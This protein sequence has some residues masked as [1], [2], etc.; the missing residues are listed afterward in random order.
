DCQPRAIGPARGRA[1]PASAYDVPARP[2]A[3][4]HPARSTSALQRQPST[5]WDAAPSLTRE[6][7]RRNGEPPTR[8]GTARPRAHNT[9]ACDGEPAA[10]ERAGA[11]TKSAPKAFN[12]ASVSTRASVLD[13]GQHRA[14]T[15]REAPWSDYR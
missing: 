3:R 15:E 12:A 2:I 6:G 11:P 1:I 4:R 7:L 10:F 14:A 9:L 5:R 8:R 13:R